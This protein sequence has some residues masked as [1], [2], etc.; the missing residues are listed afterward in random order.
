M[1]NEVK[2]I[3]EI[4][5]ILNE[6]MVKC[7]ILQEIPKTDAPTATQICEIDMRNALYNNR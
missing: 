6:I 1:K 7:G 4:K 2:K 3:K 5:S